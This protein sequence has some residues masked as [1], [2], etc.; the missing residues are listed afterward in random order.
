MEG[1]ANNRNPTRG[2]SMFKDV[3]PIFLAWI[4]TFWVI[5]FIGLGVGFGPIGVVGGMYLS[6]SR[7]LFLLA[8][9][10][11]DCSDYIPR[12]GKIQ[13]EGEC[14]DFLDYYPP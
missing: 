11:D 4:V 12:W 7:L 13:G 10:V 1:E 14:A 5:L 2:A 3:W 9:Q 6:L 8:S